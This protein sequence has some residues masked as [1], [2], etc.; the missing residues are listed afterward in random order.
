MTMTAAVQWPQSDNKQTNK[1]VS[2]SSLSI[3][4]K[5]NQF[6]QDPAE[7]KQKDTLVMPLFCWLCIFLF[8]LSANKARE[9][10]PLG[11]DPGYHRQNY[12]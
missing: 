10:L 6:T 7:M 4:Y 12:T 11:C 9:T 5:V 3:K 2:E 1:R 8:T